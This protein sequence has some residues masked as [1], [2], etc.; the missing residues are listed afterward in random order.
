MKLL[1]GQ[2]HVQGLAF[3]LAEQ[4][5]P[6]SL[7]PLGLWQNVHTRAKPMSSNWSI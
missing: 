4:L 5:G 7:S 1:S 6:N 3:R 2:M